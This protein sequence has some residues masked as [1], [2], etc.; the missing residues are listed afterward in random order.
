MRKIVL[1][2]AE[3]LCDI[4]DCPICTSVSRAVGWFYQTPTKPSTGGVVDF[5]N[6]F[7]NRSNDMDDADFSEEACDCCEQPMSNTERVTDLE[8]C[9]DSLRAC[10]HT[11]ASLCEYLIVLTGKKA[12]KQERGAMLTQI[13]NIRTTLGNL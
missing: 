10:C 12:N 2:P 11:L 5:S 4:P 9:V 6:I 8:T 1:G 3:P 13:D 7:D